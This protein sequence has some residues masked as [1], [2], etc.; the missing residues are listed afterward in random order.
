MP[1]STEREIVTE[2]ISKRVSGRLSKFGIVLGALAGFALWFFVVNPLTDLIP[3]GSAWVIAAF[4]IAVASFSG[5]GWL[6]AAG[7][8]YLGHWLGKRLVLPSPGAS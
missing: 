7:G 8:F 3:S 1:R 5:L 4:P 2:E 6:G